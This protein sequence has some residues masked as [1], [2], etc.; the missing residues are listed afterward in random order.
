MFYA[1]D[2][3]STKIDIYLALL[4]KS[5]NEG[6]T[7]NYWGFFTNAFT[8]AHELAIGHK[9][10]FDIE[11][12]SYDVVNILVKN[13]LDYFKTLEPDKISMSTF[14]DVKKF[15]GSLRQSNTVIG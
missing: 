1:K 11:T 8:L 7:S 3:A 6:N 2:N 5:I 15:M 4:E 12:D 13:N 10:F 9:T 14:S